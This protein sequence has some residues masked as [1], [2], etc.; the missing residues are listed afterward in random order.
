M[1][2]YSKGLATAAALLIAATGCGD[3]SS[4]GDGKGGGA[5]GSGGQIAPQK[6]ATAVAFSTASVELTEGRT[7]QLSVTLTYDDGSTEDVTSS[8]MYMVEGDAVTVSASGLVTAALPGSATIMAHHEALAA[9]IP[10]TITAAAMTS[11]ELSAVT[12]WKVGT[13]TQLI[14]TGVHTT[15]RRSVVTEGLLFQSS[16]ERVATVDAT[17]LVTLLAG[18]PLSLGV[19]TN[20]LQARLDARPTCDYPRYSPL[21]QYNRVVPPLSWPGRWPDG[22]D[23]D[24]KLE[25]VYCDADW[26][27]IETLVVV[28]GAGWCTPCTLYAQR[29]QNEVDQL[30]ALNAQIVMLEAQDTEGLPSNLEFAWEH[31]NRITDRLP[32]IVVGDADTRPTANFVQESALVEAFPTV[33]V[34]RTSDMK[35]IAESGRTDYYLPLQDIAADPLADWSHPGMPTFTNACRMGEDEAGEPNDLP[36]SATPLAAGTV[37]GG[38][39]TDAPDYYA[40]DLPGRWRVDLDFTHATGDLDVTVWDVARNQP[41]QLN[42]QVV[43]STG[44]TDHESFEHTGRVVIQIAGYQHA[45]A[46]YTLTLTAL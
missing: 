21:L 16:D 32:G 11:V 43:G 39:C 44:A 22:R 37:T 12:D 13:T 41:A 19:V 8:V 6:V 31:L 36:E 2:I 26:S 42:G 33:F 17:G 1:R 28:V 7:A 27:N 20:G 5:G 29:I 23:F 34:I 9:S 45:S 25:D 38:I 24:F 15:G 30:A 18:G 3:D 35:M 14:V 46:P 10:A 4:S 40:I